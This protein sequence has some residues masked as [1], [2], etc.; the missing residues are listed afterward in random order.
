MGGRGGTCGRVGGADLNHLRICLQTTQARIMT[1]V[2]PP[3]PP[4]HP[5]SWFD[6]CGTPFAP[7]RTC[8][9]KTIQLQADPF[10]NPPQ[11]LLRRMMDTIPTTERVLPT[12]EGTCPFLKLHGITTDP[13]LHC[14]CCRPHPTPGPAAAA[15][16]G[17]HSYQQGR[18][19][20]LHHPLQADPFSFQP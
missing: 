20:G 1:P 8:S 6:A 18:S 7:S 4:P 12:T 5:R 13:L 3:L 14:C 9:L 16:D 17:L 15:P 10:P 11:V 19:L 2:V